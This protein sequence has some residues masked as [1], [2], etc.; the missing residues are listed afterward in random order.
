MNSGNPKS[1]IQ[2]P[3]WT[4]GFTLVELLVVI[5]IIG[6]L[7]G[8]L[9][10]AVQAAREAAR[11]TQCRN[12][13]RQIGIAAESHVSAHGHYPTGGWGWRWVGDADRGFGADQ[14]GGW[15]YNLLPYL[16]QEA[17]HA[18]PGDGQPDAHTS[19]QMEGAVRLVN[20][21]LAV[22]S[23]PTRRR[24]I[25]HRA[26]RGTF[27]A[28]NAGTN[29]SQV[30]ARGDYA[31]NAGTWRTE[32]SSGPG[33]LETALAWSAGQQ[34]AAKGNPT[35][36]SYSRWPDVSRADG[37]SF[38]RSQIMPAHVRD[39]LSNTILVGEKYLDP[40]RYFDGSCPADNE[41]V[42]SGW[43]N[44]NFR[45]TREPPFQDTAG[46]CLRDFFGSAHAG[47]CHLLFADGSVRRMSYSVDR[48]VFRR[49]GTRAGGEVIE[50]SGF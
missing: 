38:Q 6:I 36:S 27:I 29:T 24:P 42:Y 25:L 34:M 15:V 26:P 40:L 28:Y 46:A 17:L 8:L 37:L 18:L 3:R 9:L 32:I 10:P 30:V 41:C 23:C 14:P 22:M 21:P 19:Q 33:D 4:K 43:N 7:I 2:D 13:L 35:P 1:K 5:T 48:A 50:S 44:D 11:Q 31:I 47:M 12:N 20:T 39:G 16:E 49:L 45:I